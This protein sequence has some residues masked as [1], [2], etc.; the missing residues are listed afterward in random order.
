MRPRSACT[1]SLV[2]VEQVTWVEPWG[3]YLIAWKNITLVGCVKEWQRVEQRQLP[4]IWLNPVTQ[5]TCVRLFDSSTP[6][7]EGY[8]KRS[9]SGFCQL[10][11]Q[12]QS[13]STTPLC[14]PR[15]SLLEL[16]AYPG[17]QH[18]TWWRNYWAQ[19][20][21]TVIA[22]ISSNSTSFFCFVHLCLSFH[23]IFDL[24]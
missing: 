16:W 12:L 20:L 5:L 2:P 22:F 19:P 14:A 11:R 10:R 13:A 3:V 17:H 4:P 15:N 7:E 18:V 23:P 21:T 8:R 24:L 1:I 6:S 9:N